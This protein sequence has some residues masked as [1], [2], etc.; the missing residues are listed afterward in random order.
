MTGDTAS[1]ATHL[2]RNGWYDASRFAWTIAS[3]LIGLLLGASLT[4]AEQRQGIRSVFAAAISLEVA[5]LLSSL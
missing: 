2:V 3:F 5:L 4:H 1:L